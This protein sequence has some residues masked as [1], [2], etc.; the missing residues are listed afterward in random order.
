[1]GKGE[2]EGEKMSTLGIDG[3]IEGICLSLSFGGYP[4]SVSVSV[5]VSGFLVFLMG[6]W[7]THKTRRAMLQ[8]TSKRGQ[9]NLN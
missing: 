1:M 9:W 6:L 4:R 5:S 8:L 7:E 2:G 3:T